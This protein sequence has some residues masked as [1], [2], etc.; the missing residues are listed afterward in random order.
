METASM[1]STNLDEAW[2]ET[3][4]T[5]VLVG[6]RELLPRHDVL[7]DRP[8]VTRGGGLAETLL[9]RQRSRKADSLILDW[10]R[11]GRL[12]D[13]G[14][15]SFPLFLSHTQ[16][17]ERH[18]IDRVPH[19][20]TEEWKRRGIHLINQDLEAD[21]CLPYPDHSFTVV[22]MLAV[23]EH[24]KPAQ[25]VMLVS[26]VRRVLEPGGLYVLT[27]PACWTGW[28][29]RLMARL[30]FL[31][32]EE[33]E[34]HKHQYRHIEIRE[35]LRTSGFHPALIRLGHFELFMN[36]WGVATK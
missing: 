6:S 15:G 22:T 36:S 13:I 28:L 27:T 18:G 29:L 35:V 30:R 17:R 12:L 7:T 10:H 23:F 5:E 16:F 11:R 26:E 34:E 25:L 31:S 8:R 1:P 33:I 20:A 3:K 14:C 32:R 24:V 4:S 19:S 2:V 21:P 9:A